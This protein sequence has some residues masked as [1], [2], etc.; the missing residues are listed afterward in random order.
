MGSGLD[1]HS[2]ITAAEQRGD[3]ELQL[4][5]G[6]HTTGDLASCSPRSGGRSSSSA[7]EGGGAGVA[8]QGSGRV[9]ELQGGGGSGLQNR[10]GSGEFDRSK[11]HTV[12]VIPDLET[13]QEAGGSSGG[14][15]GRSSG[16]GGI[17]RA[18]GEA[19]ALI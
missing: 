17:P 15:S 13:V 7:E 9:G 2:S 19:E 12:A 3:A 16:G 18:E 14:A 10:L 4:R 11:R 5:R 6:R 1:R 8:R